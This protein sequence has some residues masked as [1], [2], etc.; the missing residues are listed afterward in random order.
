MANRIFLP[1][2][3][4][5]LIWACKDMPPV[6]PPVDSGDLTD[7][8]YSPQAYTIMV[9]PGWPQPLIPAN[10][11]MTH[12]GVQL[13]RRLFYDPILSGDSTLACAGCHSP[14]GN[15]SDNLAFSKGIDGKF[16]RRSSMPLLNVAYS[17]TFA[18][19]DPNVLSQDFFWDGRA[20]SLEDQAGRPVEDVVEM[21]NTWTNL[22]E[23]LKAH[24]TY[25]SYFRKAF[26][27]TNKSQITKELAV[28]AI[29]QFERILIGGGN[30]KFDKWRAGT[31]DLDDDEVD[32]Y[33]MGFDN[34]GQLTSV[35]LP[36][37]E[38]FHCH[39]VPPFT[40]PFGYFDNRIQ[41]AATVNDYADKGR[42]EVKKEPDQMGKFRA[43]S[44]RNIAL[45][46]PYMHDGR[47]KTL[48][49]VL[50]HYG[51]HGKN[52]PN[53]PEN[54]IQK[55]GLKI[56][57]SNPVQYDTLSIQNRQKIVKFLHCLTDTSFVNNPDI[58][59]PFH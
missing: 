28:K 22:V 30:S 34:N 23:R 8:P 56:P 17:E 47:F 3:C 38:C 45:S 58:L 2:F 54:F 31:G 39:G 20:R 18:D 40:G 32:G 1:L 49:Q 53:S 9:P 33:I 43:M 26:G 36:D 41:D 16:G 42:G 19:D 29:A 25:P 6:P 59:T 14:S 52:T 51:R 57:N 24:P 21:H 55:I 35:S 27:I 5:C 44:L 4:L 12:D 37:A 46:A 15:F 10:N 7:I 13:G 11:P 50:D 48:E